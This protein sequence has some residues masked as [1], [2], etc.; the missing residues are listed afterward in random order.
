M[1]GF[2]YGTSIPDANAK[3]GIYF[4]KENNK[5]SIYIKREAELAKYG[6]TNELTSANL[7]DLWSRI[8]ETFV[9][10]TFTVA[11]LSLENNISLSD[12]QNAL[13]L[14]GLAYKNEATGTLSDYVIEVEGVDYTPTGTVEVILGYDQ[15]ATVISNGKF[16]PAGQ[17]TG[18]TVAK[19]SVSLQKD[20]A[21]FA[22]SG[23][24]SAPEITITPAIEKIK[25]ITGVG[26]L[27]SY[28]PAQYTAPSLSSSP[29]SFATEG[30]TATIDGEILQ[31]TP[32]NTANAITGVNFNSGEYTAA[33]FNPGTLPTSEEIEI[34]T[35]INS[36]N[37]SQPTFT[38]DKISATFNGQSNNINA[39]FTGTEG[40]IQVSGTYDKAIVN[41][42]TFS[43]DIETI[44]PELIKDE[45]TVT[46]K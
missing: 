10:K 14:Q 25:Q 22:I 29:G 19:G 21:G 38:G 24:V 46:V 9:A 15:T 2:Y 36:V 33:I 40:N 34:I 41:S 17:V 31:F 26:T 45:K 43:G 6:E 7:D 39:T 1:I 20:N 5:Y 4:V 27:P 13:K 12:M 16:T 42:A 23:S 3:E 18:S 35:G 8:G 28:T 30:I 32:A 37:A 11:G 44:K